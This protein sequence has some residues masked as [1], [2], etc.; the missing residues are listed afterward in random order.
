MDS[1]QGIRARASRRVSSEVTEHSDNSCL[2]GLWFLYFLGVGPESV[3]MGGTE[4]GTIVFLPP[5]LLFCVWFQGC[6]PY[7]G[8]GRQ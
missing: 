6:G 8:E 7:P 1:S 5:S 2:T 4:D 3:P